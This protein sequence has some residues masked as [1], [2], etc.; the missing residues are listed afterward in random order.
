MD[1]RI[2]QSRQSDQLVLDLIE[3]IHPEQSPI[4]HPESFVIVIPA[5]QRN[6]LIRM[7]IHQIIQQVRQLLAGTVADDGGVDPLS[8]PSW[9]RNCHQLIGLD[10]F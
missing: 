10:C 9:V 8:R 2:F 6:D 5:I 4:T 1:R 7:Q 3:P